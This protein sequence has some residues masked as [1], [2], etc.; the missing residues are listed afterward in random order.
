MFGL[1]NV[2]PILTPQEIGSGSD[3]NLDAA[4][5]RLLAVADYPEIVRWVQF[6]AAVLLFLMVPGDPESGAFIS[7]THSKPL[8]DLLQS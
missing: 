7:M 6:P 3:G 1:M 2:A 8:E 4:V 5:A